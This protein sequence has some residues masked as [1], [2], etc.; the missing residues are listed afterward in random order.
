VEEF[1]KIIILGIVQG[2]T[3]FL[4]ISST[5]HLLVVSAL[6]NSDVAARLGGT[7]E[8]FIQIGSVI[9]VVVFYRQELWRQVSTVHHDKGVRHLWLCIVIAAIPAALA[10]FLFRDFIKE[11]LFPQQ[12]APIVVAS[13]LIT[14]GLVF[15]LVETRRTVDETRLTKELQAITFRQAFL[16]GLA[17]MFAL[18]PGV[19]RSGS[20]IIGGL[21][22]G[23]SRDVAVT[24]TFFL[25]IPV[26][27]GAT[28]IDFV[29]S[30]DTIQ[31]D[32][33]TYLMIGALISGIISWIAIGWLLRYVKSNNFVVFGI[34]RIVAGLVIV[35]LLATHIL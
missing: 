4:P 11:I 20:T 25:A 28:L 24:F 10:G 32:D 8:I 16:I 35:F 23:L 5:G 19:S 7:L 14:V 9:A 13:A 29:L 2:I 33:F 21:L 30:L 15:L 17:Q 31:P 6:L 1:I 18:I 34:Y 3:E 12:N 26:L 22:S 27:G